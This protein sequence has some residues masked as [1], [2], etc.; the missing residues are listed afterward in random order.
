MKIVIISE[1]YSE[2][3][4]YAENY[5]PK[6][7]GKLGHEVHL[8]TT[9]LQVYATSKN[10]DAIYREHLGPKQVEKGIFKKNFFTLHRTN[11][12]IGDGINIPDLENK[13]R[14]I[15]PDIVY[16]FE[17]LQPV[18]SI[19]LSLKE[20]LK[21]K[22]F[23]ESRRHLSVFSPP[24]TM[25][26]KL[27]QFLIS[28]QS[29]KENKKI[30][31][32]YPIAEDVRRVITKYYGI[33]NKKCKIA[34]LAVDTDTYS[35]TIDE[36]LINKLRNSLGFKNTE[37]ICLY[38]G[39]FTHEKDPL[40]LAKAINFLQ[41]KGELEFKALFVGQGDQKY[42]EEILKNKGCVVHPFISSDELPLFYQTFDIGVWP[43]QESTSQLDAAASGLPIIISD[44]VEDRFRID[45]NGLSFEEG[46][47]LDLAKKILELEDE[48]KRKNL[49]KTGKNKILS[50][51][52]WDIL[53]INKIEDFKK[54]LK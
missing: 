48:N 24:K 27:K 37:I 39:R 50:N 26:S 18:N 8:I 3:M 16:L 19:V 25:K 34:S 32:F 54:H 1:W 30:D 46:N 41:E 14:E 12:L 13:L 7:L 49:G 23:C 51:Y 31:L 45:G 29:K 52:S 28:L 21:Y 35:K 9:D 11:H 17:I 42:E 33:P 2:K 44:K 43:K 36:I 6:A 4:G 5:L 20:E 15:I 53:A 38:T 22:V 10:Y 47:H 40:T